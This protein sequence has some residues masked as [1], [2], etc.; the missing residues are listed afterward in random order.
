MIYFDL[1]LVYDVRSEAGFEGR[2]SAS[3]MRWREARDWRATSRPWL[4]RLGDGQ[5]GG[6]AVL[7]GR[8]GEASLGCRESEMSMNSEICKSG[9]PTWTGKIWSCQCIL[10]I[11]LRPGGVMRGPP[12]SNG[13]GKQKGLGLTLGE[14]TS[15]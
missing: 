2:V 7:E 1:I 9:V 13:A 15:L 12:G 5:G 14:W 11:Y 8:S 3:L 10:S 4:T 6:G